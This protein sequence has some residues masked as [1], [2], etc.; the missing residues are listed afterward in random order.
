MKKKKFLVIGAG[1]WQI[2]GI[3][4]LISQKH[5][6]HVCDSRLELLKKIKK[7]R[8]HLITDFQNLNSL[9]RIV[10]KH[11]IDDV[12]S[13]GSDSTLQQINAIKKKRERFIIVI[14]QFRYV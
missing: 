10:K 8:K 7:V 12:V 5:E 4:K 9:L 13:F 11:G 1:T 2:N 3:K 6:V 14:E